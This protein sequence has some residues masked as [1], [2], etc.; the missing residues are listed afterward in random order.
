MNGKEMQRYVAKNANS[1][2][3]KKSAMVQRKSKNSVTLQYIESGKTERVS[4]KA[5]PDF[6]GILKTKKTRAGIWQSCKEIFLANGIAFIWLIFGRGL[7]ASKTAQAL[8][9]GLKCKYELKVRLSMYRHALLQIE[10]REERI[11]EL[12]AA[13]RN[14]IQHAIDNDVCTDRFYRMANKALGGGE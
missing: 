14:A 9:D 10:A 12:E 13:L 7:M 11:A 8:I 4:I 1:Q 6:L 5:D 2:R 3:Q